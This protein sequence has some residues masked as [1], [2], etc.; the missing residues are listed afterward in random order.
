MGAGSLDLGRAVRR[1]GLGR[2]VHWITG[3]GGD[4]MSLSAVGKIGKT[5]HRLYIITPIVYCRVAREYVQL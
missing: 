3:I 1:H 2:E 4:F 5:M